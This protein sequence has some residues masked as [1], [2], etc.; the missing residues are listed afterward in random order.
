MLNGYGGNILRIDLTTGD[1]S[2]TPTD[3]ALA[4]KW[5]GGRGFGIY[6]L[7]TELP[8]NADPMGPENLLV[9]SPGPLSG[10]LVPGAGKVDFACKSPL[11]GGYASANAGGI[12]TAEI[13]YAGY[14]SII[15]KGKAEKPVYILIDNDK[16]EIRDAADLW[17]KGSLDTEKIIKDRLG[18]EFQVAPIGPGGE[19]GVK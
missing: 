10:T 14:D 4:E 19:N 9:I 1:I 13:K 7:F 3:P 15:L 11:T 8:K 16:V 18:E 12:L 17:G 6:F 2:K 5:L